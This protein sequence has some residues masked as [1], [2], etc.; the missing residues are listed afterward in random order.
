VF[1]I[2][3]RVSKDTTLLQRKWKSLNIQHQ[4]ISKN[5]TDLDEIYILLYKQVLYEPG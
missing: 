5:V 3:C 4:N 1:E 2:K